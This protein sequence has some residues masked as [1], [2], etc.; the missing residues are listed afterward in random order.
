[1]ISITEELNCDLV[2]SVIYGLLYFRQS[3]MSIHVSRFC[4]APT[5]PTCL[6]FEFTYK[7]YGFIAQYDNV[8]LQADL[9]PLD[10]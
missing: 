9:L 2:T 5:Q 6:S 8:Q 1:M 3:Q 4:V 7:D 10:L